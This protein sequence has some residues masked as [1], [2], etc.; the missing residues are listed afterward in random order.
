MP[1]SEAKVELRPSTLILLLRAVNFTFASGCF[2]PTAGHFGQNSS[3]GFFCFFFYS[4]L[5]F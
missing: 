2:I 3:V 1:S 4:N 5:P